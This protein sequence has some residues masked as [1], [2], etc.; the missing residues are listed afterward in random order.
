MI[1]KKIRNCSEFK[2]FENLL[3]LI[4]PLL[5]KNY[6]HYNQWLQTNRAGLKNPQECS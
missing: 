6:D 5:N 3:I 4:S 2:K 1:N